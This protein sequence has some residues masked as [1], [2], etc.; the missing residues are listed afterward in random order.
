MGITHNS[1]LLIQDNCL[2]AKP[3]TDFKRYTFIEK[4]QLLNKAVMMK[5]EENTIL[6]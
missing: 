1:L 3:Q 5:L 2:E 6:P 4:P